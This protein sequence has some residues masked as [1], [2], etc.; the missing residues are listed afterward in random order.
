MSPNFHSSPP[1]ANA[2]PGR[3]P[4]LWE[5]PRDKA[6]ALAQ[7]LILAGC[8]GSPC[9]QGFFPAQTQREEE[10]GA[11]TGLQPLEISPLS[12]TSA[13]G[14]PHHPTAPVSSSI[15]PSIPAGLVVKIRSSQLGLAFVCL[16]I[17]SSSG[18][19]AVSHR[20]EL[21]RLRSRNSLCLGRKHDTGE[22]L[23]CHQHLPGRE[24]STMGS[25][26]HSA[27]TV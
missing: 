26:S 8:E 24:G 27:S 10:A 20:P 11:R 2:V 14:Q 21:S 5:R 13:L 22:A 12:K 9:T 16:L 6:S 23:L 25:H 17:S 18:L 1:R 4:T 15:P 3:T 19:A 7:S